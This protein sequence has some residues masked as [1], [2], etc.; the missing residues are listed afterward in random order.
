DDLAVREHSP[1][2]GAFDVGRDRRDLTGITGAGCGMGRLQQLDV[3]SAGL[4]PETRPP[5]AFVVAALA[6]LGLRRFAEP[7]GV[8]DLLPLG[9]EFAEVGQP[10]REIGRGFAFARFDRREACQRLFLAKGLI[11]R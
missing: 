2:E 10:R 6:L 9:A 8:R 7:R 5:G 4:G 11:T 1:W 3:A